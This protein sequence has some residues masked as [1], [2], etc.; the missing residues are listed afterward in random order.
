MFCKFILSNKL[1]FILET[2]FSYRYNS[3]WQND[4][5]TK[6]SNAF[7]F[8]PGFV[9]FLSLPPNWSFASPGVLMRIVLGSTITNGREPRS[10]LGQV[11]NFKLGSFVSKKHGTHTATTKVEKSAQVLPWQ[12]KFVHDCTVLLD[13]ARPLLKYVFKINTSLMNSKIWP[14]QTVWCLCISLFSFFVT[15]T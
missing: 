7:R 2:V 15:N 9:K 5:L 12:L 13:G 4:K 14:T 11:F 1:G 8:M 3:V 6:R 10:C